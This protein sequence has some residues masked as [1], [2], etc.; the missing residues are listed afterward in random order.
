VNLNADIQLKNKDG[1]TV[2]DLISLMKD[3]NYS[4][5]VLRLLAGNS[6]KHSSPAGTHSP[7][8]SFQSAIEYIQTKPE[9]EISS[10]RKARV[11][12]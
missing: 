9:S 10:K 4:T 11:V 6:Y 7:Q 3:E 5:Q 12:S 1:F 8:H 2:L